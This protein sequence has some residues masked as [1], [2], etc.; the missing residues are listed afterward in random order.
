MKRLYKLS[1]GPLGIAILVLIW[2]FVL[3]AGIVSPAVLAYPIEVVRVFPELFNPGIN[4]PDLS[5]T[6]IRSLSAF[7]LS[8]PCGI[9]AGV[10]IFNSGVMQ[11]SAKF[12]LDFFRSIPATALVPVFLILYGTGDTTKVAVGTFSS[13]LVICLATVTGLERRNATRLAV[14]HLLGV[15]GVRRILYVDLPEAAPELFLGMRAGISLALILVV[16]SEMLIGSNR[17]LGRVIAD[18][19]YTDDKGRMYAAIILIGIVGYT[20][21]LF[22]GALE[23][24]GLWWRVQR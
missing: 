24:R 14:A 10:L 7:L 4:G 19:L 20:Y 5:S 22:L 1:A 3:R 21:N 23:R 6:V 13:A 18:M 8:I 17:G 16:V 11:R 9:V 15:R 2:E 12:V